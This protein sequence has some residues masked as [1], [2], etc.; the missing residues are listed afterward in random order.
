MNQNNETF[1]PYP[2][3]SADVANAIELYCPSD[4]SVELSD[5]FLS[6][7]KE[8]VA[9]VPPVSVDDARQMLSA[10]SR[11]L[12]ETTPPVTMPLV[13]VFA[14]K[15]ITRW[16]HA[17][18]AA[19]GSRDRVRLYAAWLH[20]LRRTAI[21]CAGRAPRGN[22]ETTS[23]SS[24]SLDELVEIFDVLPDEC[25]AV[26]AAVVGAGV[27]PSVFGAG[28]FETVDGRMWA[29]TENG[30]RHRVTS[31]V[32]ALIDTGWV[33]ERCT[34]ADVRRAGRNVDVVLSWQ[35]AM[36]TFT[37]QVVVCEP[38]VAGLTLFGV[39]RQTLERAVS[40][41]TVC[42]SQQA[43]GVL[44]AS[45]WGCVEVTMDGSIR[46][47]RKATSMSKPSRKEMRALAAKYAS[48]GITGLTDQQISRVNSYQPQ[49]VDPEVW[50]A[51]ADT[52]RAAMARC[53]ELSESGFSQTMSI[54][55]SLLVWRQGRN[56]DVSLE[57]SFTHNAID[58]FC[59]HGLDGKEPSTRNTYRTRLQPIA[60]AIDPETI[61]RPVYS[62]RGHQP[63]KPCYTAQEERAIRRAVIA[64]PS[65]STGRQLSAAVA[66][67]AGAGL[68]TM[69]MRHLERRHIH[70]GDNGITIDVPGSRPRTTV[71]REV[72]EPMLLAGLEGLTDGQMVFGIKKDRRNVL[73]NTLA[74]AVLFDDTPTI[75]ISRLRAT[76]LAAHMQAA[77]PI[78]II[79]NA[80]GLKS[81]RALV[82]LLPYLPDTN[83]VEASH[84]L[85][86]VA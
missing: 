73:G 25:C 22:T 57:E 70:V 1:R 53:G 15:R 81:A 41:S 79:L 51:V 10:A 49:G 24:Y 48:G 86:G 17:S 60:V 64:H 32:A 12:R 19:G 52:H 38:A 43:V 82:D 26:F 75:E 69:D 76:W 72:Y 47:S 65:G 36:D 31:S 66:L 84:V 61:S 56:L 85:R 18:L 29:V 9:G 23:L 71:V 5:R 37:S 77:V 58:L 74:N 80:A 68:D 42:D 13:E 2:N 33:G 55:M 78:H 6:G 30:S 21:G 83:T 8:L 46:D 28:R 44:R 7:V 59:E 34:W 62:T 20:R 35:T 4:L 11:F 40:T 50:A 54:V 3:L 39:G 27:K 63:I 14:V 16:E 45:G 67:S